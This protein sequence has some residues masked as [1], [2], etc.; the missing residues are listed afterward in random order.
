[1]EITSACSTRISAKKEFYWESLSILVCGG[2]DFEINNE[3]S[4]YDQHNVQ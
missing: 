1:M 3:F 2:L 4:S